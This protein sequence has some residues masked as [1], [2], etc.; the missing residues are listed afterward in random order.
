MQI[1]ISAQ[2]FMGGMLNGPDERGAGPSQSVWSTRK[3]L[4]EDGNA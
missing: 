2:V 4:K 3:G 1:G